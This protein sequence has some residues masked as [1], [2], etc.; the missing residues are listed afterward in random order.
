MRYLTSLKYIYV[1]E[2]PFNQAMENLDMHIYSALNAN[3]RKSHDQWHIIILF[4]ENNDR[5]NTVLYIF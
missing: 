4:L 2:A 3:R 1:L 5:L